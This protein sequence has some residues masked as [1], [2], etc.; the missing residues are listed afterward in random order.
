MQNAFSLQECL[1]NLSPV[2]SITR[3]QQG[4]SESQTTLGAPCPQQLHTPHTPSSVTQPS[5]P[6]PEKQK[7]S[8]KQGMGTWEHSKGRG[9]HVPTVPETRTLQ[10]QLPGSQL[11]NMGT[12]DQPVSIQP[13]SATLDN[14]IVC[15]FTFLQVPVPL[16]SCI[17]KKLKY[18]MTINDII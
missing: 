8:R 13:R 7:H 9:S 16:A 10:G 11:T 6:L 17:I 15:P 18:I 4:V 3:A 14:T 12:A 2:S 1:S 5:C